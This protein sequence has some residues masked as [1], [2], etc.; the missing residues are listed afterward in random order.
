VF[1][2]EKC[3]IVVWEEEYFGRCAA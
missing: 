1:P 2:I 3:A